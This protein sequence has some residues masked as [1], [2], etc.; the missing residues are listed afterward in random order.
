MPNLARR[1][2]LKAFLAAS[3]LLGL[4]GCGY[5]DPIDPTLYKHDTDNA[6]FTA[7]RQHAADIKGDYNWVAPTGS[8]EPLIL[9]YDWIVWRKP[10]T[11]PYADL[12]AGQVIVYKADW[13]PGKTVVH[14]LV[15]KD[16]H[17][18]ILSGDNNPYSEA[19]WRVTEA[20]YLGTV[21]AINRSPRA[22]KRP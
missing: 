10:D 7:A 13:L 18:W 9:G 21:V 15:Q 16:S 20:T 22:Q 4:Q 11:A 12:R 19:S 8:M 3:L 6:A 1:S 14:R 17:G 2:F 5:P